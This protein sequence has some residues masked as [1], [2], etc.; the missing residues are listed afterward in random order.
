MEKP[1]VEWRYIPTKVDV[2]DQ[3]CLTFAFLEMIGKVF[4][5]IHGLEVEML[6]NFEKCAMFYKSESVWASTAAA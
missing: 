5:F 4:H 3:T 6:I 2:R 1:S